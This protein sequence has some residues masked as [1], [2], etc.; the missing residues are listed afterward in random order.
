MEKTNYKV[1]TLWESLNIK[2]EHKWGEVGGVDPP[3]RGFRGGG[4]YLFEKFWV[5][6]PPPPPAEILCSPMIKCKL[7]YKK[8][9]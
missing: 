7:G 1:F 9:F 3:P 8:I 6:S 2:G 5:I 4:G